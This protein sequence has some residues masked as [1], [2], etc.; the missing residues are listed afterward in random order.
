MSR[1]LPLLL[2]LLWTAWVVQAFVSALQVRRLLGQLRRPVRARFAA[3]RPPAV[4]IV[5]VKGADDDLGAH[6]AAMCALDYPTYELVFV[7]ESTAD[8][9]WAA[10][11]DR[12]AEHP[13][14]RARV[15]V[16]GTAGPQRSQKVHNQLHALAALEDTCGE[17]H[18]WVFAD[19]DTVPRPDWLGALVGPTVRTRQTAA[20][21]GYRWL[22][23]SAGPG[24]RTSLWSHLAS[25]VNSSVACQLGRYTFNHC[26]GGSMAIAVRV[27]RRADLPGY[28]ARAVTDDYQVTRLCRDVGMRIAFVPRCL[29][30]SPVAFDMVGFFEF[31]RRQ[32][33]I[34]RVYA[35]RLYAAG[36]AITGLYVAGWLSATASLA[37]AAWGQGSWLAP[38]VAAAAVFSLNQARATWRAS[39]IELALGPGARRMLGTTLLVDRWLTPLS[40]AV[41]WAAILAAGIGRTITWRGVRYRLLGPDHVERLA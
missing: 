18:V 14:R 26:W 29:V 13:E 5:P 27:A 31:V 39:V 30:P 25:V 40:M 37:A 19:A 33:L 38:A 20:S 1:W 34:T 35:P 4:V 12:L 32:Y 21:T 36:L 11:R 9:A 8:P 23:P 22:I 2:L 10:L 15:L 7:V 16:A 24:G 28:L 17:D 3:H 6:V 41:H